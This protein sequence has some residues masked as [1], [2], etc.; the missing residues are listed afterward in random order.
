MDQEP[1]GQPGA[2]A[3]VSKDQ[4]SKGAPRPIHCMCVS[5][6][7]ATARAGAGQGEAAS[8]RFEQRFFQQHIKACRRPDMPG[9]NILA[10]T[11]GMDGGALARAGD[12][13]Q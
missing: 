11:P 10:R 5:Q 7:P 3:T 6:H 12:Q 8:F 1:S 2:C 9:R 4:M 13:E